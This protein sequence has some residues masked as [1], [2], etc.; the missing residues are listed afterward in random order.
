MK[1]EGF[2]GSQH[3]QI[4][5]SL[6][7]VSETI[8]AAFSW[9]R[10]QSVTWEAVPR[11]KGRQKEKE[12]WSWD[13]CSIQEPTL[14]LRLEARSS[15]LETRFHFDSH[16]ND[17]FFFFHCGG[18]IS[19]PAKLTCGRGHVCLA[20]CCIPLPANACHRVGPPIKWMN[21]TISQCKTV[22]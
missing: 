13:Q 8:E 20:L 2:Q 5:S 15:V 16:P 6:C 10:Q 14:K 19:I 7:N 4:V 1:I 11:K 12:S 21:E 3:F 18:D 17:D 22:A 9:Y